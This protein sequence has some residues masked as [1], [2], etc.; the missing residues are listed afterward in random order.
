MPADTLIMNNE[1]NCQ[2][3]K[4]ERLKKGVVQTIMQQ[5]IRINMKTAIS[6]A[7]V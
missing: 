7:V 6:N 1:A 2:A 5:H 3:C 4:P